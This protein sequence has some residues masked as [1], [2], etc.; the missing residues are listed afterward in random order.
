M[1]FPLQD[2][3]S[4][5]T[6]VEE[7]RQ[8]IAEIKAAQA[9][10]DRNGTQYIVMMGDVAFKFVM[11]EKTATQA[12]AVAAQWATRFTENDAKMIARAI[13]NAKGETAQAMPLVAALN[14]ALA[15]KNLS[16]QRLEQAIS[17][18]QWLP[19]VRRDSASGE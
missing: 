2:Q 12:S 1:P 3:E 15:K 16:L 18:I 8:Q 13:K 9:T 4:Q 5:L 17:V 7:L 10:L 19:P 11:Q 14:M 6:P